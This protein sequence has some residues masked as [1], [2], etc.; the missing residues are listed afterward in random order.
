[1]GQSDRIAL[2]GH[3]RPNDRLAGD[4]HDVTEHPL[5]L[6]IQLLELTPLRVNEIEPILEAGFCSA[7]FLIYWC[8]AAKRQGVR[9]H[10]QCS[11]FTNTMV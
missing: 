5:H 4:A 6:Q 11:I 8:G 9:A 10:L 2:S 1:M 7:A 3:D